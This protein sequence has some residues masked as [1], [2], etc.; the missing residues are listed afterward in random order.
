MTNQWKN[1]KKSIKNIFLFLMK[2]VKIIISIGSVIGFFFF[3]KYI[4]IK[5]FI[6]FASGLFM[7]AI[8]LLS[9]KPML[10]FLI[11]FANAEDYLYDVG[12]KKDETKK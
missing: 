8:L 1:I 4:G 5:G 9:K 2:Y 12:K 10:K 6:G 11:D 7:M 3:F